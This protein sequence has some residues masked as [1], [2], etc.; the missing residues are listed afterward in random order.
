MKMDLNLIPVGI[1]LSGLMDAIQMALVL[2][3]IY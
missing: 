3:M 2:K 1:A